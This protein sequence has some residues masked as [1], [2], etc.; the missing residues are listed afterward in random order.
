MGRKV[1][2]VLIVLFYLAAGLN[3]FRD[4][5]FYLPLI[6][7]YLPYPN[8][9]NI[10]SG[11]AEMLLGLGLVFR[12]SRKVSAYLIIAMLVAFIPSHVYF[13]QIGSCT[14]GGLCVP[15]WI[16]WIRLIVVHPLLIWWAWVHR[17]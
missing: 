5:G 2:L 15:E 13:I 14:S 4:P 3:H 10:I 16:G 17:K 8:A 9:I 7:D 12:Q 1:S 6:P 11:I